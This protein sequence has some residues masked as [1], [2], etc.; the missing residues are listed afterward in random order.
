LANFLAVAQQTACGFKT[1]R[2]RGWPAKKCPDLSCEK[3][4]QSRNLEVYTVKKVC[5]SWNQKLYIG[6]YSG[7]YSLK[8][9][10]SGIYNLGFAPS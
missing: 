10:N 6:E 7:I 5:G 9:K 2:Y 3:T 1:D 8:L 4:G